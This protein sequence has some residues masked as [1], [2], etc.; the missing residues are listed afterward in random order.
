[1]A[2][3]AGELG[4]ETVAGG[5]ADDDIGGFG[6]FGEPGIEIEEIERGVG[7]WAECVGVVFDAALEGVGGAKELVGGNA[8]EFGGDAEREVARPCK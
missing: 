1:M 4:G 8:W 5:I 3:V 2:D 7:V 6:G